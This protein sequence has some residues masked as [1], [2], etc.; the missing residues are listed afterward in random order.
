MPYIGN[1][2][3]EKYA[4][5][6]VQYFTTSATT[7]YTLDRAVANELDIRL[8]INNVIQEPGAGKAYTAANTTLTLTS[9]T[10]G[11]DTMYAVYIGKAVQTVNP[12]ANSVGPTALQDNS[13][14]NAKLAD[15][16]QGDVIYYGAAG[17]PAQLAAGTSGHVLKTQGAGANPIWAA[18]Q[19]GTITAFT[20]GADNR[21]VTATSSTALNGEA[22]MTF[23][24]TTLTVSGA[25]S[26]VNLGLE[27]TASSIAG[28]PFYSSNQS[29]Y[30]HDVSATDSTAQ[31]NTAYGI[32]AMDAITTGDRNT[33][34]GASAGGT[35]S[36]G[37]NN[38][39]MGKS[40]GEIL[41]TG[42]NNTAVG[43]RALASLVGGNSNT[44]FGYEAGVS[45]TGSGN[46]FLG[47]LAGED[48]STGINNVMIGH[49]SGK[50]VNS[51][52]NNICI[53]TQAGETVT[54]GNSSIFIGY[55]AGKNV[56]NNSD[57]SIFIGYQ[58]GLGTGGVVYSNVYIG[59]KAGGSN[60]ANSNTIVGNLAGAAMDGTA[61]QKN[62]LMGDNSG[63]DITVGHS[64][65]AIGAQSEAS[66]TSGYNN[67]SLGVGSN[68]ASVGAIGQVT[69]GNA[70]ITSIRCQVQSISSLSDERDKTDITDLPNSSGLDF[71]NSL[72][73]RTFHW[74]KREWYDDGI[75]DGSKK[76]TN[77][78]SWKASSGKKMGFVA[79]EVQTAIG[80]IDHM[81]R[82]ILSDNPD[83][84]EL[85]QDFIAP[86]V[87]AVQQLSDENDALKARV[88]ALEG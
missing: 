44:A 38:V 17:A 47:Y 39:F 3:A 21:V 27:D 26:K 74:D 82:T 35:L 67:V 70:S 80:N 71:I 23:D 9:A 52:G 5:F 72:K 84:L 54:G 59:N 31:N 75:P 12:G 66:L 62:T 10:A 65:A 14:T 68:S 45:A 32:A 57:G 13:V 34:I 7:S 11:G 86:L 1:T 30:T 78:A 73:P 48:T 56:N 49:E 25:G 33:A 51:G 19:A 64:N 36:T 15:A 60:D 50:N 28:I 85:A 88:T 29:I 46:T 58:A 79:Q 18:D 20:N 37:A 42:D 43:Y 8:V 55:Q 69:L 81:N 87:K 83:K 4:A 61:C 40:A 16:T 76:R 22:N 6:N 2:P 24:G 53:G 77:F 63:N 41:A